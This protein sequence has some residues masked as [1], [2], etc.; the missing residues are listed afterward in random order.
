MGQVER[1]AV[2]AALERLGNRRDRACQYA[3]LF[4]EYQEAQRNIATNG[5]IVLHPRT[6]VPIE[7]PYLRIRDKALV[8]L[9][10][11]T[12]VRADWLWQPGAYEAVLEGRLPDVPS[13]AEQKRREVDELLEAELA[14]RQG[15]G[16]V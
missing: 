1:D 9:H 7:N 13:V 5:T 15:R 4:L 14:R 12:T 11:M 10:R 3:D 6:G 16:R 8:N 2:A